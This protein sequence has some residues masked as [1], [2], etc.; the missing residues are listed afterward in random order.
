MGYDANNC[1]PW[2]KSYCTIGDN[3]TNSRIP[4]RFRLVGIV[5]RFIDYEFFSI[6]YDIKL[7][8]REFNFSKTK[9]STYL[10]GVNMENFREKGIPLPL[11]SVSKIVGVFKGTVPFKVDGRKYGQDQYVIDSLNGE[12]VYDLSSLN[13]KEIYPG[14]WKYSKE[15][16][17]DMCTPKERFYSCTELINGIFSRVGIDFK[18]P[19]IKYWNINMINGI[20]IKGKAFPGLLTSKLFGYSRKITTGFSK[21]FAKEYFLYIIKRYKQV[22]DMSLMTVGGREKRVKRSVDFK[23][24]KTR[25]VLMME[26]IP[27]LLGQSVAVPLTKAFQRLNEGD[28]KSVV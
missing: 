2:I 21:T 7:R 19:Y 16:L 20:L 15:N 23:R 3:I 28:R 9:L 8:V 10:R 14:S 24:L 17:I 6:D 12:R 4:W 18:L 5:K 26:D 11:T 13:N 22:F 27:T 25:V 1:S